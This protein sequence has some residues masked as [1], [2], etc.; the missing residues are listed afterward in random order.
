[1][2]TTSI[3]TFVLL[4]LTI[5]SA[6]AAIAHLP[7]QNKLMYVGSKI[8]DL[9]ATQKLCKSLGG[10]L[11]ALKNY[12][13]DL[14]MITKLT[15]EPVWLGVSRIPNPPYPKEASKPFRK[16]TWQDG[17]SFSDVILEEI[18]RV[19]C[20]TS[21]CSIRL[22]PHPT[23]VI[24][25]VNCNSTL[26]LPLCVVTL[27]PVNMAKLLAAGD[28]FTEDKDKLGLAMYVLPKFTKQLY[29]KVEGHRK[30]THPIMFVLLTVCLSALLVVAVMVIISLRG[31]HGLRVKKAKPSSGVTQ[32]NENGQRSDRRQEDEE[33]GETGTL[34]AD[35]C[36]HVISTEI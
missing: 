34:M 10:E 6:F 5:S 35:R 26:N 17:T 4:L 3:A 11:P 24:S 36:Q 28:S 25:E 21:C 29:D 19:P 13:Q 12:E 7:E 8:L 31:N 2:S 33:E 18:S 27:N 16:Y 14:Q 32:R 15:F 20:N 9:P 30:T 23:G 1:M 22:R